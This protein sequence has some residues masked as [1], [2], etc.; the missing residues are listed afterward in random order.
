MQKFVLSAAKGAL[1]YLQK[2]IYYVLF[3]FLGTKIAHK[4][5]SKCTHMQRKIVENTIKIGRF[6][7]ILLV[8]Y[9]AKIAIMSE[10]Y[11]LISSHKNNTKLIMLKT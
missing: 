4:V 7:S 6:L 11:V 10:K 3:R 1:K 2:Q 8:F 5:F 9:A